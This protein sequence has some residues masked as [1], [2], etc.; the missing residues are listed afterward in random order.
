M[1]VWIYSLSVWTVNCVNG[2]TDS[3]VGFPKSYDRIWKGSYII[4]SGF[5]VQFCGR[6]KL[7]L[8]W[9]QQKFPGI[10]NKY[11]RSVSQKGHITMNFSLSESAGVLEYSAEFRTS[12]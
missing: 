1:C 11:L 3:K 2:F 9:T 4:F 6:T 10:R 5:A 7:S 12:H 8:L